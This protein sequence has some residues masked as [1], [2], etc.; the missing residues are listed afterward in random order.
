MAAGRKK[1]A[2]GPHEARGPRVEDPSFRPMAHGLADQHFANYEEVAKWLE[3][4]LASKG[5]EILLGGG[6]QFA[7]SL[8][9]MCRIRG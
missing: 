6:T 1:L 3:S 4:W 2:S 9:K 8:V 5:G 7:G